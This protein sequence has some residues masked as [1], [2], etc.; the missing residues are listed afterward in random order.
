MFELVAACLL[1][2]VGSLMT[3][4]AAYVMAKVAIPMKSKFVF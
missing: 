1:L 4:A 3:P 2:V